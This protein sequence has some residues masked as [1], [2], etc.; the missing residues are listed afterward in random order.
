MVRLISPVLEQASMSNVLEPAEKRSLKEE[1]YQKNMLQS[2][3]QCESFPR[4]HLYHPAASEMSAACADTEGSLDMLST[5]HPTSPN[6]F[7]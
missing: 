3:T 4:L 5:A 7:S 2:P 1:K 6:T